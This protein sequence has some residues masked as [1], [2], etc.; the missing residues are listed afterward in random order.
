MTRYWRQGRPAEA[1]AALLVNF[2]TE[3]SVVLDCG[4]VLYKSRSRFFLRL[5]GSSFVCTITHT[6][7]A[8]DKC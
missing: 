8:S 5:A 2:P 3:P 4:V 1:N 7:T 6:S